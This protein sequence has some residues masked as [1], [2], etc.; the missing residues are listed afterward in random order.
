MRR[1][2]LDHA[3]RERR[4]HLHRLHGLGVG[5][6][7]ALATDSTS[8]STI[9]G[10]IHASRCLAF[11][12]K[13]EFHCT[14]ITRALR[15]SL[16]CCWGSAVLAVRSSRAPSEKQPDCQAGDL[17]LGFPKDG[18]PPCLQINHPGKAELEDCVNP[19]AAH[20]EQ[21]RSIPAGS[22]GLAAILQLNVVDGIGDT[23]RALNLGPPV[24]HGFVAA[25]CPGLHNRHPHWDGRPASA[26][27]WSPGLRCKKQDASRHIPTYAASILSKA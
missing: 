4:W 6:G 25:R 19:L 22:S 18:P 12:H 3:D 27:V 24:P 16:C 13:H 5:D 23:L 2:Q 15:C 9:D 1:P 21:S 20:T 11:T 8:S 14:R 26:P 10:C 17:Q 7:A